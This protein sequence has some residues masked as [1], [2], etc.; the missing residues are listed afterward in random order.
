VTIPVYED[1]AAESVLRMGPS[2]KALIMVS[3]AAHVSAH[4]ENGFDEQKQKGTNFGRVKFLGIA[5]ATFTV[6]FVVLPDEE[7][8]FYKLVVPLCRQKGKRG[9]S[10]PMTV[11]NL[12]INRLG[13]DTVTIK[14][15]DIDPPDARDGR[16]VTLHLQ[17]WTPAPTAA[18][19]VNSGKVNRDPLNIGEPLGPPPPPGS[20]I[21]PGVPSA[22]TA[23]QGSRAVP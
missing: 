8:T 20:D 22:V 2:G 4:V 10:P 23:N 21:G 19:P 17:E 18:K 13:I 1:A 3:N 16:Q 15:A 9:N 14:S 12:Q 7:D 5:P 6:T 11:A